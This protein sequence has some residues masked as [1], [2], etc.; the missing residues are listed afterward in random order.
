[1]K[2]KVLISWSTG[3]DSA[4]CLHRIQQDT[5]YE[6]AGLFCTVN[7][8]FARTAMHAVRVDLLKRQAQRLAQPLDIIEIPYPCS[9][10][11]YEQIMARFVERA[12]DREIEGFVFGDLFLEDIRAYRVAHLQGSGIEPLFPLWGEP[13]AGLARAMIDGGLKTVITCIDPRQLDASLAGR[14]FNHDFLRDLPP[15]AD[16]CGENGEFHSFVYDAPMFSAPIAHRV[17]AVVER[18]GFIFADILEADKD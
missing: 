17:G 12:R 7:K 11:R 8:K 3:K 1:M 18:D 14:I 5:R 15:H 9:N 10:A 2:K 4:W 13:T 6:I 16:P